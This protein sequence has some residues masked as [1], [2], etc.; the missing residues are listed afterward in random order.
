MLNVTYYHI[1]EGKLSINQ[2]ALV[3]LLLDSECVG[4][5]QPPKDSPYPT[6]L[7]VTYYHINGGDLLPPPMPFIESKLTKICFPL[8]LRIGLN[9]TIR[10]S[11]WKNKVNWIWLHCGLWLSELNG[12]LSVRAAKVSTKSFLNV[13]S[14]EKW[15]GQLTATKYCSRQPMRGAENMWTNQKPRLI[16]R[17]SDSCDKDDF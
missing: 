6:M 17:L 8:N 2:Y 14:L 16:C 15:R 1:Q 13:W 12:H 3:L 7:D 11:V 4:D 9:L 10:N 5:L